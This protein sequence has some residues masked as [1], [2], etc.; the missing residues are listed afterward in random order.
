MLWGLPE[1][2]PLCSVQ[3]ELL[4]HDVPHLCLDQRKFQQVQVEFDAAHGVVG[5]LQLGEQC[6]AL[7]EI[8]AV[9]LRPHDIREVLRTGADVPDIE[10]ER[11][12][13][14]VER[15]LFVWADIADAL[16]VNRP[17]AMA[18]NWSKPFQAELI[19]AQ[20]FEIPATLVTT[21]PD[22]AREFIAQHRRVIY[23]SVSGERSIVSRMD[24]SELERIDE[25][26]SCPTQFQSHICGVDW[27]VHVIR[28][29]VYACEIR[30]DADDYRIGEQEGVAIEIRAA[31]LPETIAT[32][33]R[34]LARQLN[35][36]L[37]GI[38]L[39]RTVDDAWYC[40]EVNTAPAFS[41][42]EKRSGQPLTA[43]VARMLIGAEMRR[44]A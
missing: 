7:E 36:P 4:R 30:C 9:F 42:Y 31:F 26:T 24:D 22:A 6:I 10:S 21:T 28:D 32:R 11:Q 40:F 19:R 43:A 1:D 23:K 3:R 15:R 12:A 27:R 18:S 13:V 8:G 37:A 16:V 17:S 33:C 14:A 25:V 39:R 38:D 41:Y 20:G 29:E 2:E 35:L 34:A 5:R 44:A